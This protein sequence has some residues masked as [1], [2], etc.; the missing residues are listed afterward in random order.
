[1][2][3]YI[4]LISPKNGSRFL[5]NK[6]PFNNYINDNVLA[7]KNCNQSTFDDLEKGVDVFPYT[8]H[9]FN[10]TKCKFIK[11]TFDTDICGEFEVKIACKNKNFVK[12][13]LTKEHYVKI[14]NLYPQETYEWNVKSLTTNIKSKTYS[15]YITD[16]YRLLYFPK[17]FNMRDCGGKITV[18]NKRIKYGL[19]FR[20][21][22]LTDKK[23]R[24][25]VNRM[26]FGAVHYKTFTEKDLPYFYDLGIKQEIDL[27]GNFESLFQ[28]KSTVSKPQHRVGYSRLN[29]DGYQEFFREG[30]EE[31]YKNN[32]IKMFDKFA[33]ADKRP[34]FIHCWGGADRTGT[35]CFLLEAVLGVSLTDLIIDYETTAFVGNITR[36]KQYQE[37]VDPWYREKFNVYAMCQWL[38]NF[39]K[40]EETI[41]QTVTRY[42]VEEIGVKPA[43]IEKIKNIFLE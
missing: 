30:K 22:E 28:K 18:D 3:D 24:S 10:D 13:I 17:L 43:T 12:K 38:K 33:N 4:S 31:F 32:Y 29:M 2:K 5:V 37:G 23:Y 27:R 9:K 8:R 11:L 16:S 35:I 36:V 15:F 39:S 20:G 26:D 1:M 7:L 21:I 25:K 41:Q 42:F 19:L 14:V 6:K 34:I 40:D